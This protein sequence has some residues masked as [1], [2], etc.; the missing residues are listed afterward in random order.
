MMLCMWT[1]ACCI[2]GALAI[3]L[4]VAAWRAFG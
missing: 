2:L 4:G 3:V 1:A